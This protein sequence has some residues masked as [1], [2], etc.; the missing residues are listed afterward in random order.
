[1]PI[2][3]GKVYYVYNNKTDDA[4]NT[5]TYKVSLSLEGAQLEEAKKLNVK[6]REDNRGVIPGTHVLF[7]RPKFSKKGKD[8]GPPLVV[9]AKKNPWPD[10]IIIGNGTY[11]KVRFSV[12]PGGTFYWDSMQ[13]LEFVPYESKNT[14]REEEGVDVTKLSQDR[15]DFSDEAEGEN[16]PV[17]DEEEFS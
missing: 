7:K 11:A 14:F 8:V 5:Q 3:E 10:N 15:E 17:A 9:D 12:T 6:L 4:F 16:V 13:V 2:L 1:M